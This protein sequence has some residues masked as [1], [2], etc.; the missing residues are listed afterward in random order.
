MTKNPTLLDLLRSVEEK[1]KTYPENRAR[2]LALT[3][4]DE[5]AMWGAMAWADST[6]LRP[7]KTCPYL[8]EDLQRGYYIQ[9]G[10]WTRDKAKATK[11]TLEE[12]GQKAGKY[13][14]AVAVPYAEQ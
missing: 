7:G 12:A 3:K 1:L 10:V 8:V 2:A 11:F 13:K 14:F 6:P 9:A 4:L 5:L